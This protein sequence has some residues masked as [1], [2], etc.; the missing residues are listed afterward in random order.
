MDLLA[1]SNTEKG[2]IPRDLSMP[3]ESLEIYPHGVLK[4][5]RPGFELIGCLDQPRTFGLARF[6]ECYGSGLHLRDDTSVVEVDTIEW[7]AT[8]EHHMLI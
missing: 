8:L 4:L 1:R 7:R 3:S 5:P 2:E 6:I